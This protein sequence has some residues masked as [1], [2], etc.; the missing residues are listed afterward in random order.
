M[1]DVRSLLTAYV[2]QDEPPIALSGDAVLAAARRSRRQHL[3]TGVVAVCV[4]VLALGLAVVVLPQRGPVAGPSCPSGSS[5]SALVERLSCVVGHAVRALLP[6]DARV[7]RLG[8]EGPSDPFTVVA[9]PVS[10]IPREAIFRTDI[11][12]TDA[13]GSGSVSV[14]LYPTPNSVRPS[15][16]PDDDLISCSV[17]QVPEGT[18]QLTSSQSTGA[19]THQAA[20]SAPW[21]YVRVF[22]SDSGEPER[23][24]LQTP[25][26]RPEP[27]LTPAQVRELALTPGLRF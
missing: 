10:E 25:S 14:V 5:R 4:V 13:R 19:L 17:E 6:P 26:Q 7:S 3:L 1:E 12:V 24:D 22:S 16:F 21:G 15:C 20:L 18:L 8:S 23:K 9:D 11:R 27:V 2:T